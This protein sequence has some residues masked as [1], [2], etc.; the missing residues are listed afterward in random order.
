MISDQF[1]KEIEKQSLIKDFEQKVI[2]IFKKY[3]IGNQ[4]D[5]IIEISSNDVY[6]NVAWLTCCKI[7][8]HDIFGFSLISLNFLEKE[9]SQITDI[10]EFNISCIVTDNEPY[11]KIIFVFNI[12]ELEKK[13]KK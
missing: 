2:E 13:S 7:F 8:Y 9:L 6:N 3:L 4:T 5:I 12:E 10:C 11:L 1:S